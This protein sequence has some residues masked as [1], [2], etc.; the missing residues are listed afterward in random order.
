MASLKYQMKYIL[1]F[2][3]ELV[4]HCEFLG[5]AAHCF[6]HH[7]IHNA[8]RSTGVQ[9][10]EKLCE[11]W[12]WCDRRL[13]DIELETKCVVCKRIVCPN[14]LW[15]ER[16]PFARCGKWEN[17]WQTCCESSSWRSSCYKDQIR[18]RKKVSLL[19]F[20]RCNCTLDRDYVEQSDCHNNCRQCVI[21]CF[22]L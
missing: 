5:F 10:S 12:F 21:Q 8:S 9:K 7:A 15:V 3:T 1:H 2:L 22:R 17:R 14:L 11:I 13:P 6:S 4:K 19:V 18:G 20:V 16:E